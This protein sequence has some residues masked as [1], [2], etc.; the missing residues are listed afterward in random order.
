M[1]Y[2]APTLP[3]KNS[4]VVAAPVLIRVFVKVPLEIP[5]V[6]CEPPPPPI[7]MTEVP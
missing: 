3:E 1:E 7:L 5:S 4:T 6:D 2:S